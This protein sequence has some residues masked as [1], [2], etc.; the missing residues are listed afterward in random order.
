MAVLTEEERDN[1][2][3]ALQAGQARLENGQARLEIYVKAIAGKLLAPTEISEIEAKV[4][5]ED[6]EKVAV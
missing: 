4:N 2:L 1:I 6:R 3:V 5:A